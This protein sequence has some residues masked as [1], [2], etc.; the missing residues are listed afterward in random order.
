MVTVFAQP[1][2]L[3][4]ALVFP[5]LMWAADRVFAHK[6]PGAFIALLAWSL[7]YS[8]YD[9]YMMLIMLVLYCATVFFFCVDAPLGRE[10]RLRRFAGWVGA[11]VG[12][13]VLALL[14]ACV[15]FLPQA[16][17]LAGSGRLALD[18]TDNLLYDLSFYFN[19]FWGF[20]SYAYAGGDAYTGFNAL[21]PLVLLALVFKRNEHRGLLVSF[22]VLT[23]MMLVPVFGRLMNAMEYP[24]DRWSWAYSACMAYCTVRVL[25]GLLALEGR[26]RKVL[27]ACVLVYVVLCWAFPV[28]LSANVHAAAALL[29][30][31]TAVCLLAPRLGRARS[32]GALAV[33]VA[34]SAAVTMCGYL[35]PGVGGA[36][37]S[38]VKSGE[39]WNT[40]ATESVDALVDQAA[41]TTGYDET[42][43]YDR[44]ST[45]ASLV[46]NS[47]LVTGNMAP[48]FYS[49]MYNEG[50]DD[51][52]TS[53]GLL[54]TEGTN[55]RYGSL[56]GR[57]M[58]EALLGVRYYYLRDGEF[59]ALPYSF[60]R[61]TLVAER[62]SARGTTSQLYETNLVAPL[63]F[64]TSSVIT[65]EQYYDLPLAKRQ[66]ALLQA[67]VVESDAEAAGLD[68]VY[69]DLRLSARTRKATVAGTAHGC[70]VREDGAI[71]ATKP[72]ATLTLEV[73][74][75]AHAERYLQLEG[76]SYADLS[77]EYRY[78]P[79][80]W[81]ALG[82]GGRLH[83]TVSYAL[84]NK[85]TNGSIDIC[86]ADGS[87]AGT[88]YYPNENDP[89]YGGKHDW[90][91]NL[92]YGAE[93][94]TT[95]V[96]LRFNREGV[97]RFSS[98]EAVSQPM[99]GFEGRVEG[100]K[101]AGARDIELK[102]NGL[103]CTATV[104][105]DALL[106]LSVAY[107]SGWSATVDGEPV[108]IM[109]ADLGFMAL[110]LSKGAHEVVLT[111]RTPYLVEGAVLSGA[112]LVLAI[113]TCAAVRFRSR[114]ARRD[115]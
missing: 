73:E 77:N 57:S 113:A 55:N 69:G 100:L 45:A 79:Q 13:V 58:L 71:V 11:F 114:K 4:P 97:Y 91:C 42:Y 5:L 15:L 62:T 112:G 10:G 29:A 48:D 87:R 61:G 9:S 34:A 83:E 38:Q 70:T 37:L 7:A 67:V 111:Y 25:P 64:T 54:D 89:I 44:T 35:L 52:L 1:G 99:E 107:S 88:I 106:F 51:L 104:D 110:P 95:R 16:M 6:G 105:E 19:F 14:I 94:E 82:A 28:D 76:L 102:T 2:S 30:V 96:T 84:R 43:R 20:T 60:A 21:A 31:M 49:S 78:T 93:G 23:V 68:N 75:D 3:F 86:R 108:E 103:S 85:S 40:H 66:E 56:S 33:L 81:E 109:R 63:A 22:A 12:Y 46:H 36:V 39:L 53:L 26:Q 32:L 90:V 92:G 24:T 74:F 47:N 65:A 80:E 101:A 17:A 59:A 72:G 8:F 18:R 41:Q 98:M 50:V 27:G 115:R